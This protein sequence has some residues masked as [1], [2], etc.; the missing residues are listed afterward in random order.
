MNDA[1][2]DEHLVKRINNNPFNI[3]VGS[4]IKDDNVWNW[5]FQLNDLQNVYSYINL[6]NKILTRNNLFDYNNMSKN[7]IR[8]FKTYYE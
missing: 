8:K 5:V 2:W 7:K 4:G 6:I 1:Y 3:P